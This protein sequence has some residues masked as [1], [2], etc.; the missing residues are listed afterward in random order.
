MA[1]QPLTA[2]KGIERVT[3]FPGSVFKRPVLAPYV[4]EVI[5]RW[6]IS[7][8]NLF[9]IAADVLHVE[10]VIATVMLQ[11]VDNQAAQRAAVLAAAKAM[12]APN[13]WLLFEAAFYTTNQSRSVRNQFVHHIWGTADELPQALL[14]IDPRFASLDRAKRIKRVDA[15]VRRGIN[16]ALAGERN[17]DFSGVMVWR[18]ADFATESR[19][20]C[21]AQIIIAEL[22][23]LVSALKHGHSTDS[24]RKRLENDEQVLQ[25]L[26]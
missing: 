7:E 19:N 4:M 16:P 10:P 25:R 14:L 9:N 11:A 2:F 21:R 17:F 18:E 6:S 20:A 1:C 5:E 24:I 12:L 3:F 15:R 22:S 13:D 8:T 23:H 26:H